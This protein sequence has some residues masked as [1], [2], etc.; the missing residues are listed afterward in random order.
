MNFLKN[1]KRAGPAGTG[2]ATSAAVFSR[3][4]LPNVPTGRRQSLKAAS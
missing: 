3:Y 2:S 1:R 4:A